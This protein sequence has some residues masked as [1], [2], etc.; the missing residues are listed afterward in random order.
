MYLWVEFKTTTTDKFFLQKGYN[1]NSNK[2]KILTHILQSIKVRCYLLATC[3]YQVS[4]FWYTMDLKVKSL[5][6]KNK[7]VVQNSLVGIADSN[8]VHIHKYSK[9][10]WVLTV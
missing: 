9:V 1:E 5:Y 8:T 2:T 3:L 4:S 7:L 6:S 10:A